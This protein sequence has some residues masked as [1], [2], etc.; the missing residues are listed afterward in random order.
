M[1]RIKNKLIYELDKAIVRFNNLYKVIIR[2]PVVLSV[3]ETINSIANGASISRYGDGEFDIILGRTQGFQS[4]DKELTTR[5]KKILK[6]NDET[7]GFIVGLPDC[8]DKLDHFTKPAQTHWKIRLDKERYKW[9]GLLNTK[10]PYYCSQ[11][12]R[13]YFDWQNKSKCEK[14]FHMLKSIWN[15][16]DVI[17]VEGNKTRCG[18]GNDIFD[19]TKSIKRIICPAENAFLKYNEILQK[20][21]DFSNK[22]DLIIMALGPTATVLAYDLYKCGYWAF[23]AG[24]FDIEYEWM[25]HKAVEKIAIQG[26]YVN[27]VKDGNIV[28]DI[29]DDEYFSQIICDLSKPD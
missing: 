4:Q 23:D 2:Q 26:K 13:F 3:E 8:F 20:I 12:T 21:K 10:H 5:L 17:I 19:N 24:H 6:H 18:V 14:W 7:P 9:V 11:I 1:K 25:R 28:D 15:N 22:E 29:D 16:K 27:E